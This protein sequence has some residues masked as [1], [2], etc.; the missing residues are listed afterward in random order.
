MVIENIYAG[1]VASSKA[2]FSAAAFVA[3]CCLLER[4]FFRCI[5]VV[6][7]VCCMVLVARLW[8]FV[9]D[10]LTTGI[11]CKI[12]SIENYPAPV[13]PVRLEFRFPTEKGNLPL[14]V[15]SNVSFFC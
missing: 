4:Y 13:S 6:L 2:V 12:G 5:G 8:T 15:I 9:Y 10:F 14:S 1:A 7:P 3:L 11:S